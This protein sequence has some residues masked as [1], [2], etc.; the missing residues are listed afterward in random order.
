M[1]IA[2]LLAGI[3]I[4]PSLLGIVVDNIIDR[5]KTRRAIKRR[6]DRIANS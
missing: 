1:E 6:L 2:T 4:G 3:A 5:V